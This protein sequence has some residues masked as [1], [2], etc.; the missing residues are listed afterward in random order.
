MYLLN[1]DIRIGK[2]KAKTM[3]EVKIKTSVLNLSD[4]ATITLPGKCLN[5][6]KT[7]ED[8]VKVGDEVE[9]KLGYNEDLQTEFKGYLKRLSRQDNAIVLECEDALYLLNKEVESREYKN[10]TVKALLFAMLRQVDRSFTLQCDYDFTYDKFVVFHQTAL[11]VLKKVHDECKANIWFEGNVLHVRP[12]YVDG[13]GERPIIYDTMVNVQAIDL[14][15][16]DKADRKVDVEVVFSQPDGKTKKVKYGNNGGNTIRKYIKTDDDY[17]MKL[18]AE[19]EF[20]LW[21]YNGYE[22]SFTAWLIPRSSA[23]GTVLL[24]DEDKEDGLYYVTAVDVE[25]GSN[26]AK[27]KVQLGRR[28]G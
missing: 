13:S 19:S 18:A 7:I 10:I 15:W 28:I 16:V 21:N 3:K 17:S 23:G 2:Y 27:R 6:G 1:W 11:D 14:K 8:K 12:V 20:R 25:F 22:G 24:R 4:T 26:G 5:S 9:I